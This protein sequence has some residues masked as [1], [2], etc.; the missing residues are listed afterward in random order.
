MNLKSLLLAVLA[1]VIVV[2]GW[3]AFYVVHETER[4]ILLR[5]GSVARAD[6][7]PGLGPKFPIFDEVKKFNGRVLTVDAPVERYFTLEQKPVMVDSFAKWRIGDVERFYTSTGGDR[8]RADALLQ[9]RV[10][11]GLRNQISRRD[12]HE[13][14]SGERDLL[15]AEL[16]TSLNDVMSREIGVRVIDVRVKRIDLP[17]DVEASVFQRM[18]SAREIEAKQYRASGEEKAIGIRADADRQVTVIKA[19]A[20]RTAEE[21]RGAGDANAAKT[22]AEAFNKDPEFYAF[23]R[24]VTAYSKVFSGKEDQFVL[25]PNSDFFRYLKSGGEGD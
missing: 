15:M 11:E 8:V 23:Y 1:L 4:A 3:N 2:L 12:M 16:T 13:V 10:N 25:D 7:E 17:A 6:L 20:Y 24:R 5:F 21:I 14:I 18:N 9:E 19:Q 22:Y